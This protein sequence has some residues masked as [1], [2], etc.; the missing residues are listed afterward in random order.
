M[1]AIRIRRGRKTN[2]DAPGAVVDAGK[3]VGVSEGVHA[4]NTER[5]R[6]GKYTAQ[7]AGE[8]GQRAR[9]SAQTEVQDA[10]AVVECQDIA[11]RKGVA[12]LVGRQ[13]I[14]VTDTVSR[15]VPRRVV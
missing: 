15:I 6:T 1:V 5:G 4:R 9:C 8:P 11:G 14:Q 7:A 3:C 13:Q 10:G 2:D 12:R